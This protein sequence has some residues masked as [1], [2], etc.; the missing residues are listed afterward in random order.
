M[1]GV[2]SN[3]LDYKGY[4]KMRTSEQI[5]AIRKHFADPYVVPDFL[6]QTDI[7]TLVGIFR[8]NS[9]E[10]PK[11]YKNTGP[12]TLDIKSYLEHDVFKRLLAGIQTEIGQ[13]EITA[14]FFFETNYPHVIHNDDTFEL[15]DNVY[16]AISIP[17]SMEGEFSSYPKLCFFDQ[18]YFHGPAKFFNGE[19]NI[20]TYYNKQVYDYKDVDGI[21]NRPFDIS[22]WTQLFTHVRPA[23]LDGLT[24]HSSLEWKPGNAI[25]FDSV[26]LHCASDFRL[27]KIKSKLGL[28]IFTKKC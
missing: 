9:V 11:V 18:H 21:T 15:P 5:A 6:S 22:L 17:L 4:T 1:V 7:Q 20:P 24:L 14:A 12:V 25:I 16:K 3:V 10:A 26:R 23:W 13:H 27:Q 28:S 2:R 8:D 19:T